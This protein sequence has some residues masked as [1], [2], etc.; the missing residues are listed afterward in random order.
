M[1]LQ[2][3][4]SFRYRLY[5]LVFRFRH[6]NKL[7]F[8]LC[9]TYVVTSHTVECCHTAYEVKAL[10]GTLVLDEVGLAVEKEY[11]L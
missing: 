10:T 11:R 1:A 7:M 2:N 3:D 9:R 8:Y 6:N 5:H 4:L